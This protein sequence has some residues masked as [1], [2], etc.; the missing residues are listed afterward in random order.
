MATGTRKQP[1][2][3][4][5]LRIAH[6]GLASATS[7]VLQADGGVPG[8]REGRG[9]CG[10]GREKAYRRRRLVRTA[11][12]ASRIGRGTS[13]PVERLQNPP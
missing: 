7:D 2:K 10:D 6:E 4:K 12:V 11:D 3:Q 13:C 5:D 8:R 9:V 1:T